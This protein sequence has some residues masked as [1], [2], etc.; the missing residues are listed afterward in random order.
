MDID[1]AS[2]PGS[3]NRGGGRAG[4]PTRVSALSLPL[5]SVCVCVCMCVCMCV[6]VCTYVCVC[7]YEC[8]CVNSRCKGVACARGC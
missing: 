7:A 1:N 2:G 5:V 4:R 6:C 3:G 8:E